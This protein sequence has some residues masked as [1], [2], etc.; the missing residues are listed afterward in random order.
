METDRSKSCGCKGIR[1]CLQCEKEYGITKPGLNLNDCKVFTY[2]P[3]CNYAVH[4]TDVENCL[5]NAHE[6]QERMDFPGMF[7]KLDFLSQEEETRLITDLDSLPWSLSQSGRRKQNF[8]PKCNFKKKKLQL[9][10]FTGFPKTTKFVQEKFSAIDLMKGYQT[11][12]QC[13]LE[14]DPKRGASIDP[15]IDDCWIWGDRIVTVNLLSDSIL[16]MTPYRGVKTKYNLQFVPEKYMQLQSADEIKEDNIAVRIPMPRRSLLV[17]Y[18][19]ARYWWEHMV[20]REDITKRRVCIAYREFTP[21]YLKG[22]TKED[23]GWDILE[24][25]QIFW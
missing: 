4:G 3:T 19:Q 15:H 17:M 18:G 2:C 7:I 13:T 8:G 6:G 14:Y 16:T 23:Q 25:A 5:Q 11:V 10:D 1:T 21:P 22:G 20:L 12:E 9:G 24:K